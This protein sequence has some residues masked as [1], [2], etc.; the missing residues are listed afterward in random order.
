MDIIKFEKDFVYEVNQWLDLC[1]EGDYDHKYIINIMYDKIVYFLSKNKLF[2][3][4]DEDVFIDF[5]TE[6][7]YR[8]SSHKSYPLYN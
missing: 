8:Y 6:Y 7:L 5:L 3:T 2:L 1:Y 4:C